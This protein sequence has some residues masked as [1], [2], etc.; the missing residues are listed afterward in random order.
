MPSTAELRVLFDELAPRYDRSAGERVVLGPF[1]RYFAEAMRGHAL[2]IAA[3][4]GRNF[5]YYPVGDPVTSLTA[6]DL[7]PGMLAIARRRAASLAQA[8]PGLVPWAT[9]TPIVGDAEALPFADRSFD[10]VGI[11][12]ALCTIPD[13]AQAVREAVRVCRPGGRIVLL[14]HVQSPYRPVAWMLRRLEPAQIAHFGCHLTR[15]TV[16]LLRREGLTIESDRVRLF[17]IFH[18]IVGRPSS[19]GVSGQQ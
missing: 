4:S 18:L 12:L 2:E 3:G 10:S 14:E 5:P 15:D 9:F 16:G 13:P 11:S 6:L 17:G 8:H 19:G 7:S 1:R